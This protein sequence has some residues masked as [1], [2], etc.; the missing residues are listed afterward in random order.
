M[1][2]NPIAL[3]ILSL[4]ALISACKPS[5]EIV[6]IDE[7]VD[8]DTI[9]IKANS[10]LDIYRAS[11]KRLMDLLHSK[12]EVKFD[13]E[14][15]HLLGKASLRLK[16]YFYPQD[17]L[18]L[19][20]KGFDIQQVALLDS[21][22][23]KTPLN[24]DY[25]TV[26]LSIEL[27]K[28]Y[29]RK[30]TFTVWIDYTAKPNELEAGGS[31]AITS[32]IGL[33]FI[34]PT[35]EDSLKP[36]Q[37][38]TQGETQ[39]NSCWFPTIDSPNEKMTQ[40]IYITVDSNFK[41][42]SNGSLQFQIENTDGTRTDYWKQDLPH[43]PYLCM[44]AIGEYAIVRDKWKDKQV[45]YYVEPAFEKYAQDIF[46]NTVEMIEFFS[47][48]LNYPYPWDKY[49]QVVVRDYVSGAME[50]TSAVIYGEFMQGD[51]RY[52][53]DNAQEEIVAHE[54]FHHWFGDL[55]TCESWSNLPLNES[56]ATYG[57][58]LW[59]EHKYG[60]D[61]AQYHL[62][63][64]L[65]AYLQEARVNKNQLIRYHY[66]SR[67]D[68][69]DA[70]SYQKGGR[71]LHMLRNYM[72]DEAFFEGLNLYLKE[73]AFQAVEIHQLRLAFEQVTGEDL[74]WFFN[75]WFLA[76]GHPELKISHEYNPEEKVLFVQVEQSQSG[77]NIPATYVLH[78][79]IEMGFANQDKKIVP[80]KV[81]KRVQRFEITLDEKP[82]FV[83][84]DANNV[85]LAQIEQD[86][87]AEEAISL[88]EKGGNYLDRYEAL[89]LVK[90]KADSLSLSLIEK[91]FSD[92]FWNI[93]RMALQ[94]SSK[95]AALKPNTSLERIKALAQGDENSKVRAAAYDALANNFDEGVAA[96]DFEMG[97]TDSS[98]Q[99]VSASLWGM[100]QA[101]TSLGLRAA[102][103]FMVEE[104]SD[105]R[106]S[107]ANIFAE[108]GAAK[109][110]PYFEATAAQLSGFEKYPFIVSYGAF[111]LKQ[112]QADKLHIIN[113]FKGHTLKEDIWWIRMVYIN[114]L[115]NLKDD[116]RLKKT[117]YEQALK[118]QEEGGNIK[119]I[120]TQI[121]QE[122][123][124][125][126][127]IDKS[128][129]EILKLEDEENLIRIINQLL[130]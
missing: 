64:D 30:D 73:N 104:N 88:Y 2:I 96:V 120:Q 122:E 77:E 72:G 128:L 70:H 83:K 118:E 52:L 101:D 8:L 124:L 35:G 81:D 66:L 43:A 112:N 103:K 19:D 55:V 60:A 10:K 68:M 3:I 25:D 95:L 110:L 82:E 26:R 12:L 78:S 4:T 84:F 89:N 99:V 126:N 57:E 5:A 31:E 46:P 87:V 65:R 47:N 105:L 24:F 67:E 58:Y 17:Q 90:T 48:K 23:R 76:A 59:I 33:Y 125:I 85:L 98:F 49:D 100:Y 1:K 94:H 116:A 117:I 9:E 50:N 108:N 97:L 13:W 115:A 75:Q 29:T 63:Q 107:L 11:N 28:T 62:Y 18:I 14:K 86:I 119:S 109:Y 111:A 92:P 56:F 39:A 127:A 41:T 32:D 91:A 54:L 16:P 113:Q 40:E 51:A 61:E 53:I 69:F 7:Y 123:E 34:N 121:A 36:R 106:I 6:N 93:R 129:E 102:E 114:G 27:G 21:L 42:L 15:A 71:V 20:A 44:I 80:I 37:I 45:N 130:N 38:W 79:D 22:G 74:N